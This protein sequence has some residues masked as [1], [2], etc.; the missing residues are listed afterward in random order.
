MTLALVA[1]HLWQ[2]TLCA[3]IAALLTVAFRAQR[4]RVRYAFWM[5][6]SL[7]F[8][9][10]FALLQTLGHAVR[11]RVAAAPPAITFALDTVSEPFGS[12]VAPAFGRTPHVLA[13]SLASVLAALWVAGSAAVLFAW[14]VR[15]R[16]VTAVVRAAS[17]LSA[18]R[19][20]DALRRM[21]RSSGL[22]MPLVIVASSNSIEPGIF[23][24][25][26][27][28]LLWPQG[29]ST[30]LDDAQL[31][32][33]L[34]HEICHVCRRDNLAA[35]A[36]MIVEA[37][38]WLHPIVWWIGKRLIDERE[39]TCDEFVLELGAE[40]QLYAESILK[41]CEHCI[42]S[43]LMCVAGVTGSDLKTRVTR[44]MRNTAPAPLNAWRRILLATAAAA[45][46][47][48]PVATGVFKPSPA[49]SGV[50]GFRNQAPGDQG[51]TTTIAETGFRGV[52]VKA[53]LSGDTRAYPYSMTGG[54]FVATNV[55]VGNLIANAYRVSGVRMQGAP[56]WLRTDRFD[57]E[58]DADGAPSP[59]QMMPMVRK[60]LA[61]TFGLRVHVETQ[62][63]PVYALL[64]ARSDGLLGPRLRQ[65]VCTGRGE[66]P[67]GPSDPK[68]PSPLPCGAFRSRPGTLSGLWQTMPE[69]ATG[70]SLMLGRQVM[71]ATGLSG[72]YDLD[73]EWTPDTRPPGPQA[74]GVGPT[75]F[76]AIGDQLG[77]KLEE[78]TGPVEVLVIDRIEKPA[79]P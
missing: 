48:S 59:A 14:I 49:V 8:L 76:A 17:P 65:S 67:P 11:G 55:S 44:I 19:E 5:A 47:V 64:L 73:A 74:F 18:G 42:E 30:R 32:A 27:P 41:T 38:F 39:R 79:A 24:V 3:A 9:V 46:V 57:I 37:A 2:S 26:R 36:Q 68:N 69:A 75:T 63:Q 60:L 6:A 50:S 77:L 31:D 15:W 58:A 7:K 61:D 16:R 62:Q 78:R 22:A 25:F 40:P 34:A 4:A 66:L 51:L 23:G 53:N 20:V 54:R 72:K 12:I 10:P 28:R 29:L 21:E 13:L 52:T 56:D 33:I 71:D 70:L 43:P 35:V 1:D 45:A